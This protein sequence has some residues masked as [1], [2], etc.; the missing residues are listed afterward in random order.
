MIYLIWNFSQPVLLVMASSFVLSGIFTR[1]TALLK[2]KRPA[3]VE[4]ADQLS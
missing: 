2:R 3:A 4:E 1:F